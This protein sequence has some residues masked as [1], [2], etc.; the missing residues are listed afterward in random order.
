MGSGMVGLGLKTLRRLM[1]TPLGV[2][3]PTNGGSSG[4]TNG[5]TLS[6]MRWRG[7]SD[8]T[9]DRALLDGLGRVCV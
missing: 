7:R 4:K 6:A 1:I 3:S 2:L 5:T 9:V 8:G